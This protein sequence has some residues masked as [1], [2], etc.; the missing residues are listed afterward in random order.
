MLYIF[1]L[2]FLFHLALIFSYVEKNELQEKYTRLNSLENS[3]PELMN[4]I[5]SMGEEDERKLT[6]ELTSPAQNLA[7]KLYEFDTIVYSTL[8]QMEPCQLTVYLV[9]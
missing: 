4:V 6:L 9:K 8:E 1:L 7:Q 3:H 2:S 5:R